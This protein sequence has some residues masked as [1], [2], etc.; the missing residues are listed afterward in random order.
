M[1]IARIMLQS[2]ASR[3]SILI[4]VKYTAFKLEKLQGPEV[5]VIHEITI[6]FRHVNYKR[7]R[8]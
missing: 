3:L 1:G 2:Q 6:D 8:I 4:R 7:L 5:N